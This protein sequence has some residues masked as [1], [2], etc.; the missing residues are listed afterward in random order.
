M[1]VSTGAA[2]VEI[3]NEAGNRL[4]K[5][6][7]TRAGK[8][9]ATTPGGISLDTT[10][11]APMMLPAPTVMPQITRVPIPLTTLWLTV[12]SPAIAPPAPILL[13]APIRLSCPIKAPRLRNTVG[14]IGKDA[15]T[16]AGLTMPPSPFEERD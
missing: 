11:P 6:L 8:P 1:P 3:R 16:V 7:I 14:Q 4:C 13:Y 12:Q 15:T 9:A 2:S 5:S 10:A